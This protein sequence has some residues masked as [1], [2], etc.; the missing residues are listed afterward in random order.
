MSKAKAV[1]PLREFLDAVVTRIEN[2]EAHVGISVAAAAAAAASSP[3]GGGALSSS[4]THSTAF[5]KSPSSRH[6]AGAGDSPANK[7]FDKFKNT[8]VYKFA[9]SCD[10]LGMGDMGK[11]VVEVFSGMQYVVVLAS[12]SKQPEPMTDLMQHLATITGPVGVVNKMRLK[13][14]FTNHQKAIMEM[15]GCVSWVTCRAPDQLPAPFVKECIGSSDFWSNRIRKEFKGKDDDVA[16]Q[17]LEFCDNMKKVLQDLASYIEEYHKT[18]LTFNPKGVSIAEAAIRMTDNPLQD[19][20][21]E[22]I[23]KKDQQSHKKNKDIGNTVQS[24]NMAGLVS[25]LANRRSQDGSSAATGLKKVSK[26]QQTWR[27]EF[28]GDKPAPVVAPKAAPPSPKKQPKKKKVGLPIMEYQERGTKW[29]IE[30]HDK[31]TAKAVAENGLLTV[32]I[33]ESKQQVYIY[34][35]EEVTIQIKGTKLKSVIV[36]SCTKVN[37]IFPTIISGCEIV[38][39]KK[40]AVQTDG[41]CPVFTIDKTV[42]VTVYLLSEETVAVTSFTTSMSSEMNVSIPDGQGDQKELPIPEQFVH[43]IADGSLTSEVSD[44]YH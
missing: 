37:V 12:K 15:L 22:A 36:D 11:N 8:S 38:N 29:V 41:V 9:D 34:N 30:N 35:C 5:Q 31:E 4:S 27:K 6:I 20:A 13:P 32:E 16:K 25:E 26:D 40:I 19:A 21:V 17:Q 42:G 23:R 43:K 24:G 28:K 33:T 10:D 14:E 7:A 1:D 18:G 2:L 44:L 39:S 3:S